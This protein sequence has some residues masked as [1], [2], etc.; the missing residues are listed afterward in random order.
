MNRQ[1]MA[2]AVRDHDTDDNTPGHDAQ[3]QEVLHLFDAKAANWAAKYAPDGPL[4]HRLSRLSVAVTGHAYAGARVLDLGCGT[5]DLA[6]ALVASGLRVV[7][8]DIS[9]QMLLQAIR[10]H[11]I[12]QQ[13]GCAGWVRVGPA[14]RTLPFASTAFD[15]VVAASVLEYVANPAVVL[16]ECVRVLRPGGV[17]LYTVPDL[18]RPVRWAEWLAHRLARMSPAPSANGPMSRWHAY[19]IY[20][21]TSKQRHRAGWW[22]TASELAGLCEVPYLADGTRLTLRLM[23]FRR[24]GVSPPSSTGQEDGRQ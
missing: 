7:G 22:L 17:V 12:S 2:G 3:A 13:S 8:C 4:T 16:R 6:R 10:A 11:D 19:Y 5:G 24:P 15:V 9:P 18:R 23:V 21:R 20:L 14:W 1:R